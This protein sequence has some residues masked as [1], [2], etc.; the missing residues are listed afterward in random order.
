MDAAALELSRLRA[1]SEQRVLLFSRRT[2]F[3]DFC[4]RTEWGEGPPKELSDHSPYQEIVHFE[5]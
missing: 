3:F 1:Q 4:A 5:L 2:E